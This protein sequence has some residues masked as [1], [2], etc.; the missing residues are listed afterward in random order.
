MYGLTSDNHHLSRATIEAVGDVQEVEMTPSAQPIPIASCA[1]TCTN[2]LDHTVECYVQA[3]IAPAT[4]RAY[5]GDL[6]HFQAWGGTVPATDAQ[7]AA[8]LAEHASVLKVATLTRRLAAISVAHDA[9]GLT[10]PVRS[11]LIRATMRGIRR[12]HGSAQRQ[13]KPLL[14]DDL[15]AVLA[16]T[17][18]RVKDVRDRALLYL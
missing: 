3:G 14:R 9:H 2:Q 12:E 17:G 1:A 8:Y 5:R 10:N 11:P 18:E 15:F 13:A 7:L 4:R 6:D 16:A